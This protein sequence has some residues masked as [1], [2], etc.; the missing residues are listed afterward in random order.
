V[1]LPAPR[2]T[3]LFAAGC[4]LLFL[5][6]HLPFLA[7]TLED[8]D[9]VNFA[10]ALRRFD[11]AA[12]RPHPPGN[13]IYVALGK[14]VRAAVPEAAATAGGADQSRDVRD[15]RALALLGV[16]CGALLAVPLLQVFRM[17]GT[18]EAVARAAVLVTLTSPLAWFTA[19]RPLSDVPGL[20]AA[21]AALALLLTAWR[22]QRAVDPWGSPVT[23]GARLA[24][25]GRLIVLGAL[26]SGL[27]IGMRSQTAWLTVPVLALVLVDRTGRGAAGALLGASIT[28]TA[29]VL[30]WSVPLVWASG[31]PG[32]YLVA[33]TGQA[34]EDL[35]GVDMLARNPTARRLLAGLLDTFVDPWASLWIAGPVLAL[36]AIGAFV[37]LRRSAAAFVMLLVA[38]VPYAVFH[39][40]F[41]ETFTTRYALP[42]VPV[43]AF[44]AVRALAA[45]GRVVLVT[46]AAGLVLGSLALTAPALAAYARE[47]S[48]V[49]RAV[50]DVRVGL[51]RHRPRGRA[52]VM[53]HPFA[54]ALRDDRFDADRVPSVRRRQWLEIVKYWRGGGTKPVWF[55]AEPGP[56]G[57]DRHHELTLIDPAVRRLRRSYRWPFDPTAFV[58]GARPSDVDWFELHEPGWFATEGWAL[59]PEIAGVSRMDR[60]GP[61]QGGIRAFVRRRSE[62]AVMLIG[63][64]NLGRADA[65]DVRFD[66]A[67]D[68]RPVRAWRARPDP[69]FFLDM[70]TVEAGLLEGSDRFATLTITAEAADGSR[71]HV[72]A[73]IEQFDL[74][75]MDRI[76]FG[77]D[78][79]WH[80]Q[81]FS[82][83]LGRLWRWAS[84]RAVVRV[85]DAG[86]SLRCVIRGESTSRYF[87]RPSRLTLRAAAQV[88]GELESSDDFTWEVAVPA[89]VLRAA[90]GVLTLST[91]QT[92][93]PHER[94]GNGDRRRLG[95][96]IY[97]FAV[98]DGSAHPR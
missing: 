53:N 93:V 70:W 23:S 6:A 41:H 47:G 49:A 36:A 27:A 11:V 68:G 64:R 7:S 63:G 87:G 46:G 98:R 56:N 90:G 82:P 2:A 97:E 14:V 95:V 89:D 83:A 43:L 22:R 35:S 48:P 15:A 76:L 96:R 77:F 37:V 42:L 39:L 73:A 34:G 9:S 38:S 50:A 1:T 72:E 8:V 71:R 21:M 13:P 31:G 24:A 33:L 94:T 4:A 75:P 81:E 18:D 40:V 67:I 86:R 29:G 78:G 52:L 91:D 69:G 20:L 57:L 58:G 62:P 12:H 45:A 79:G 19:S 25:S 85:H 54:I 28:F 5:I 80:E 84:D 44:L 74:Q 32:R 61:V 66:L 88:L 60:R 55:L 92:F 26:V 3:R 10:L 16:I 65:P 59:T 30:I 51:D 17:L